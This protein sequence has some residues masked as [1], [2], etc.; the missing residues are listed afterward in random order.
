MAT[1]KIPDPFAPKGAKKKR[2]DPFAIGGSPAQPTQPTAPNTSTKLTP[3]IQ[4]GTADRAARSAGEVTVKPPSSTTAPTPPRPK[5]FDEAVDRE[6]NKFRDAAGGAIIGGFN[7]GIGAISSILAKQAGADKAIREL[8]ARGIVTPYMEGRLKQF[9]TPKSMSGIGGAAVVAPTPSGL[10][11]KANVLN[12]ADAKVIDDLIRKAAEEN[13]QKYLTGD[14]TVY[15]L[16]VLYDEKP[17]YEF[18]EYVMGFVYDVFNDPLTFVGSGTVNVVKA[19]IKG[20]TAAAKAGTRALIKGDVSLLA[21]AS[22]IVKKADVTPGAKIEVPE[23]PIA[24]TKEPKIK[25]KASELATSK[26]LGVDMASEFQRIKDLGTYTTTPLGKLNLDLGLITS[27]AL[28]AGKKAALSSLRTYAAKDTLADVLKGNFSRTAGIAVAREGENW[29]VKTLS[30]ENVG[31]AAS[32]QEA[33]Q[34]AKETKRAI[35]DGQVGKAVIENL[36]E[37]TKTNNGNSIEVP[38]EDGG[39]LQLDIDTPY[40]ASDGSTWV[41]D[42]TNVKVF[43]NL[44]DAQVSLTKTPELPKATVKKSKNADEYVMRAGDYIQTFKTKAE[45]NAAAAAYNTGKVPTP[46]KVS[47]GKRPALD[48]SRTPQLTLAD[49]GKGKVTSNEGKALKQILNKVNDLARKTPGRRI[50]LAMG[51]SRLLRNIINTGTLSSVKSLRYLHTVLRKDFENAIKLAKVDGELETPY[52]LLKLLKATSENDGPNADVIKELYDLVRGTVVKVDNSLVAIGDLEKRF[53]NFVT[54]VPE[55]VAKQIGQ[56]LKGILDEAALIAKSKDAPGVTEQRRYDKLVQV[57]GED[58]ADRVK[59]TGVLSRNENNKI[60][61]TVRDAF[62][63]LESDLLNQYENITYNNV[64]ELISG[65]RNGESVNPDALIKIFREI[66]PDSKFTKST[67]KALDDG[68]GVVIREVFLNEAPQSIEAMQRKLAIA[69]DVDELMGANGIGYDDLLAG[70]IKYLQDPSAG[71]AVELYSATKLSPE[72]I[73]KA[74]DLESP[75]A[76]AKAFSDSESPVTGR[77]WSA[78]DDMVTEALNQS[79]VNKF[80]LDKVIENSPTYTESTSSLGD[81][82]KKISDQNYVSNT[83]AI[84]PNVFTQADEMRAVGKLTALIRARINRKVKAGKRENVLTPA[85]VLGREKQLELRNAGADDQIDEFI[86]QSRQMSRLLGT[87]G[88]RVTRLKEANDWAFKAEYAIEAA[89][90]KAEKRPIAF[91]KTEYA[92]FS[93]LDMGD[94]FESFTQTGGRDILRRG[95]FPVT[96]ADTYAKNTMPFMGFGDAARRVLELDARGQLEVSE[97]VIEELAKRI[98]SKSEK[99]ERPTKAFAALRPGIAREMAEHLLKPEVVSYL[100]ERHLTKAVADAERWVGE[101][102]IITEDILNSLKEGIRVA[103]AIGESSDSVRLELA[104]QYLRRLALAGNIFAVQG[105]RYAEDIFNAYA[106]Q[107]AIR[108]NLP[109]SPDTAAGTPLKILDENE[110][111]LLRTHLYM[112]DMH[113]APERAQIQAASGFKYKKPSEIQ[114]IENSLTLAQELFSEVMS[115][116]AVVRNGGKAEIAAWEKEFNAAQASL[117]KARKKA[118]ESGIP[119]F[120]YQAGS[121][122]PSDQYRPEIARELAEEAEAAYLAGESGLFAR[123]LVDETPAVPEH[124][125]LKGKKLQEALKRENLVLTQGRIESARKAAEIIEAQAIKELDAIPEDDIIGILEVIQNTEMKKI[126]YSAE[127][128]KAIG[129]PDEINPEVLRVDTAFQKVTKTKKTEAG[130]ST[131]ERFSSFFGKED[132]TQFARIEETSGLIRSSRIAAA[133]TSLQKKYKNLSVS[134]FSEAF[135]FAITRGDIPSSVAGEVRTLALQLRKLVGAV[136]EAASELNKD[137]II[138]AL[139]RMG[140]SEDVGYIINESDL[141]KSMESL[142]DSLP[143]VRKPGIEKTDEAQRELKKLE[144]M[145]ASDT[146]PIQL[147]DNLVKAIS[148]AKAEQGLA[149]SVVANYGWKASGEFKTAQEAIEIGGYV[150][151]EA[152]DGGSSANLVKAL[153]TPKDGALFPP[154]I[155]KQIGAI[156]RHWNEVMNI[157]RETAVQLITQFTGF[158][159]VFMTVNRVGYHAQNIANETSTAVI[160]GVTP[161]DLVVGTRLAAMYIAETLPAEY[162]RLTNVISD[163]ATETKQWVSA[164]TGGDNFITPGSE[165]SL[166][167]QIKLATKAWGKQADAITQF[168]ANPLSVMSMKV[169]ENGKIKRKK[170]DP[171]AFIDALTFSGIFEKNFIVNNIQNLDDALALQATD[172]NNQKFLQKAGARINRATQISGKVGGDIS[173]A[174]TN[175]IRAAHAFKILRSRAWRSMDEAVGFIADELAIFHPTSK[176]LGSFDRRNSSLISTFYTWER[177]A[178]VITYKMF[179]ENYREIYAANKAIYTI[180]QSVG[181]EPQNMGTPYEE[182]DEVADWFR[183]RAGQIVVPGGRNMF[184]FGASESAVGFKVG[185]TPYEIINQYQLAID[186]GA[187]INENVTGI[188]TQIGAKI[189]RSLPLF[190]QTSA[191]AVLGIDLSRPG[192]IVPRETLGD[193]AAIGASLFPAITG[194]VKGFADTDVPQEIADLVDRLTGGPVKPR[195]TET[196]PDQELVTRLNTIYGI[197]AFLPESEASKRRADYLKKKRKDAESEKKRLERLEKFKE[198]YR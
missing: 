115:R 144:A 78:G 172:V 189:G 141:A 4:A 198:T 168:D 38:A 94:I 58:V 176:S 154:E 151:V 136:R 21:R 90:A 190:A 142:F 49:L 193:W 165:S 95:Y 184:G 148:V 73:Q 45:A 63:A 62:Y 89:R 9:A 185:L 173:S 5:T 178:H 12:E 91:N 31:V 82:V 88:I 117:N 55:L 135:N 164:L 138:D 147:F 196:T 13:S 166:E 167:R 42:G 160:R 41:F 81:K 52:T 188:F 121:W 67:L 25:V 70:A 71:T 36:P 125:L 35:E 127:M 64:D 2:V 65:L 126:A 120:H 181:N 15:G 29:A 153:G 96:T 159:K 175:A 114:K 24:T 83:G 194:P 92:H 98:M 66:D 110:R 146:H 46:S 197:S 149:A 50:R 195:E 180:N 191:K 129:L 68:T 56:K 26:A 158:N 105:G 74:V 99:M 11:P 169:V 39:K 106:M 174:Y 93:Y 192:V 102:R 60:P 109:P 19:A 77:T 155:A 44:L 116:I 143:F 1:P 40:Q 134:D 37:V 163:A 69:G 130:Y 75:A 112:L 57:F 14:K 48:I 140:V 32:K 162:G 97:S 47:S 18:G 113:T 51:D 80:E 150:A 61:A 103:N 187:S 8:A 87:L 7:F 28:E 139:K 101:G 157:P 104:R 72:W 76:L 27:S 124:K 182:P 30:G 131:R 84:I 170:L 137:G 186:T 177:M 34:L 10:V 108:G 20:G 107:F 79:W 145:E 183:Y 43:E 86:F 156:S 152:L 3:P 54:D 6:L 53:K 123:T 111:A 128:P 22:Q 133:L 59:A 118:S 171:K 23:L 16:E 100:R 119:T 132:L 179:L 85:N 33:Q 122:V 161:L 17:N